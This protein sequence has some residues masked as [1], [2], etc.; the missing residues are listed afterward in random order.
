MDIIDGYVL[1]NGKLT[2]LISGFSGAG[3]TKIGKKISNELK[4]EFINETKYYE[5]R[6]M[7]KIKL[8]NGKEILNMDSYD[9]VEWNK[10]NEEI[11]KKN[12]KRGVV[13]SGFMFPKDKI[14][15]PDL[16]IHLKISKEKLIDKRKKFMEKHKEHFKEE[17]I[18]N[19]QKIL[20][21][22]T[23]PFYKKTI[24]ES[25]INKFVNI[26]DKK[27]DEIVDI[28]FNII[29]EFIQKKLR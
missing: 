23:Y 16:H 5:L 26:S 25:I 28:L 20:D 11:E 7:K 1:E 18:K 3:K 13:V 9:V 14:N 21:E 6:N 10:L 19:V 29:I 17:E 24:D 2:I 4:M 12:K 27:E 8:T 15:K 22:I